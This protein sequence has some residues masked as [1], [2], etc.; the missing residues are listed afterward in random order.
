MSSATRYNSMPF[1]GAWPGGSG[2]FYQAPA[3]VQTP[4][5]SS[6]DL[7]PIAY[8]QIDD[9]N[10]IADQ[11][12]PGV[13]R[14]RTSMR[15]DFSTKKDQ[16]LSLLQQLGTLSNELV[17]MM[18]EIKPVVPQA[19]TTEQ[20]VVYSQADVEMFED[21]IRSIMDLAADSYNRLNEQVIVVT[22]AGASAQTR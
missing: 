8:D 2:R 4:W 11:R 14:T 5:H 16:A 22:P 10:V 9:D 12:D 18:A 19:K 15:A 1:L 20:S 6:P 21:Y 17:N 13:A 7:T 3:A